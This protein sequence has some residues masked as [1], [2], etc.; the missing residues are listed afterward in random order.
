[1]GCSTPPGW[2]RDLARPRQMALDGV[3]PTRDRA[4]PPGVPGGDVIDLH[5]ERVWRLAK[6]DLRWANADEPTTVVYNVNVKMVFV[7]G[8][9]W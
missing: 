9:L 1:M 8:V 2:T 5:G 6:P 3:M 4:S 7:L